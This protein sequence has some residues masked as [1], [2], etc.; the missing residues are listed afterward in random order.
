[1]TKANVNWLRRQVSIWEIVEEV[2]N[3]N[4]NN[5]I[6]DTQEGGDGDLKKLSPDILVKLLWTFCSMI[7]QIFME[8]GHMGELQSVVVFYQIFVELGHIGEP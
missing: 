8:L 4:N 2:I 3:N 1:M 7:D 5:I 6:K